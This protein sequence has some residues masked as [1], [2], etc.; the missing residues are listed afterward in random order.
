MLEEVIGGVI[1][2]IAHWIDCAAHDAFHAINGAQIMTAVDALAASG[3]N[4]DV[5]VV[6]RHPDDFMGHNLPDGKDQIKAAASNQTIY[7]RGPR[8]IQ[9]AF[10]LFADEF[11]R[12]FAEGLDIGPPVMYSEKIVRGIA[13]HA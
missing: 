10:R 4:E 12:D 7:L 11:S 6:V 1:Q 2:H 8:I 13:E 9:L 3:A 5:L